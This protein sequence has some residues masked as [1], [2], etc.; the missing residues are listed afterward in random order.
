MK[1]FI[2]THDTAP[3]PAA[4]YLVRMQVGAAL[5][6]RQTGCAHDD[7]GDNISARN[8]LYCELTALYWLWKHVEEDVI[9]LCHYRRYFSP[10]MAPF[11]P[12]LSAR[13]AD[14]QALISLDPAGAIFMQEAAIAE[15]IVPRPIVCTGSLEEQYISHHGRPQDWHAML[16]ALALVHPDEARDARRFFTQSNEL[17]QYNMLIGRRDIVRLYCSWLFPVLAEAERLLNPELHPLQPRAL[18]FLSERLFSWW[19]ESRKPRHIRRPILF[20]RE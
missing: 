4:Q 11:E 1:V 9:G 6:E 20:I 17:T 19:L 8:P 10:V 14:V 7:D 5:A 13:R 15:L 3:T 18:G 16:A 12:T 2:A